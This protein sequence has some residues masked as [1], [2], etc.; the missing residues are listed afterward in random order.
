MKP[1]KAKYTEFLF[2]LVKKFPFLFSR[3]LQFFSKSYRETESSATAKPWDHEEEIESASLFSDGMVWKGMTLVAAVNRSDLKKIHSWMMRQRRSAGNYSELH[4]EAITSKDLTSNG[5]NNLG[6]IS[7]GAADSFSVGSVDL[8]SKLPKCCYVTT[9]SLKRG[10][11]Y[12]SLYVALNDLASKKVFNVDV[13]GVRGYRYLGS[14]N[15]FSP[16]FKVLHRRYRKGAIDD[17]IF[18]NAKSVVL[19]VNQAISTVMKIWG[20]K[21]KI[22]EF[23]SVADFCRDGTDS[24]FYKNFKAGSKAAAEMSGSKHSAAIERWRGNVFCSEISDDSSEDFLEGHVA[25]MLG[26][27]G[28]FIKSEDGAAADAFDRYLYSMHS[29]IDYYAYF[30]YVH[31]VNMQFKECMN[32]VSPIFLSYTKSFRKNLSILIEAALAINLLHERL[33]ALHAGIRFADSKYHFIIQRRILVLQGE[34]EDLRLDINKRKDLNNGELQLSNLVWTKWY[35]I[36]VGVL[37]SVQIALALIVVDWT[38]AGREKNPIYLNLF[39]APEK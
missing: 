14:L 4:S 9:I 23:S 6:S 39:K 32:L 35:S 33:E 34:V 21:K 10:V 18:N 28:V 12:L 22:S 24:Y 37:I 11:T 30:M 16:R 20:V 31:E 8:I 17:L 26:V 7:F 5:Y 27:S 3:S 36:L 38:E 2:Y 25:Q 1:F 13:R 19:E 29:A 15:P